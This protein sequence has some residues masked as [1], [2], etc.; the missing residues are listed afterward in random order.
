LSGGSRIII[1]NVFE[2]PKNYDMESVRVRT[3]IV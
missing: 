2:A 3:S 1:E